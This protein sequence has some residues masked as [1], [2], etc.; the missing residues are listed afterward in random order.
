MKSPYTYLPAGKNK[1][2]SSWEHSRTKST[3]SF[4]SSKLARGTLLELKKYAGT[5]EQKNINK[6][7][8]R[9]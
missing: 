6:H 3:N 1:F 7:T 5:Y 4:I 2:S 9:L 8:V